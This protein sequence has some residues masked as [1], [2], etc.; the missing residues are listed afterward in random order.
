MFE[1][2]IT[3]GV[4]VIRSPLTPVYVSLT[5]TLSL[6]LSLSLSLAHTHTHN[7]F[8]LLRE[9]F[10]NEGLAT[11]KCRVMGEKKDNRWEK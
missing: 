7:L 10:I 4:L 3:L 8:S 6:S 2:R 11:A 1:T 5:T 9:G